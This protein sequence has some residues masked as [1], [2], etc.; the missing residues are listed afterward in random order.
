MPLQ[1][2][3]MVEARLRVERARAQA[4]LTYPVG[5]VVGDMAHETS[6]RRVIQE[7]LAEFADAVE[8]L[9]GLLEE[10]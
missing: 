2:A 9:N 5:Q 7:L 3:A 6:C 4:F 1:T 10:A 8:R